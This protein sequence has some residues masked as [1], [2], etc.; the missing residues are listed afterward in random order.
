MFRFVACVVVAIAG[1]VTFAAATPTIVVGSHNLQPNQ[2]DQTVQ[3]FVSGGDL[4]AGVNFY[5]QTA[6]G[7]P[8]AEA[9]GWIPPGTAIVAPAITNLDLLTGTIFAENNLGQLG[10]L[11]PGAY[12][13][14]AFGG[15][16]LASGYVPADGLLATV[17]IDT[18]GFL[19]GSFA[20]SLTVAGLPTDFAPIPINITDGTINLVNTP[21]V[22]NA[23][24]D[25]TVNS[26]AVVQLAGSGSDPDGSPVTYT[27]VRTSGPAVTLSSTAI[28]NPTFT[29]PSVS[30]QTDVVLEL[31]VSDGT[32]TRSDTVTITVR[33]AG[34]PPVDDSDPDPTDDPPADDG[35]PPADD[36]TNPPDDSSGS[37]D[38]TTPDDDGSSSTDDQPPSNSTKPG[39]LCGSGFVESAALSFLGLFVLPYAGRSGRRRS[40][41][42]V[43]GGNVEK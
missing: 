9:E 31:R 24:P 26:G 7:G 16:L 20:L 25:Q 35:T 4:V 42:G 33:P 36:S 40:D 2:P 22:V 12:P 27:W 5:I 19:S 11:P 30:A 6:N 10:G 21:P 3:I 37:T 8:E 23:G 39:G 41:H 18:T 14:I 29:A 38:D 32:D 28:P 43:P 17:T 1:P 34:A 13:Q 15:T